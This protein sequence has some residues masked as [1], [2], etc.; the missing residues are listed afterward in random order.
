MK[1]R[2]EIIGI[3]HPEDTGLPL[4][5]Q[6]VGFTLIELL[7]VIGIIAIA[8]SLV[9][10]PAS[11][12]FTTASDAQA[13]QL[14]SAMLGAARGKAIENQSYALVHCQIGVDDSCWIAVMIHNQ[15]TDKFELAEG[16]LPQQVPGNIAFGE[17]SS[18]FVNG[19]NYISDAL[20]S[21]EELRDF[22][23]F[24]IVFAP[25]GALASSDYT[26]QIDTDTKIFGG[27]GATPEQQIWDIPAGLDINEPTVKVVTIFPYKTLVAVEN[28]ANWLEENG[29]FL[30]INPYTG[31]L[32]P[33]K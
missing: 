31:R 33:T 2:R 5:N 32:I 11:K 8:L 14:F 16:Y 23:T 25:S 27:N 4:F 22:T 10:P 19:G 9:L 15:D 30:C 29:Q 28:R 1:K 20:D 13:R 21:D 6:G 12:I 26:P 24:N 17:I 18:K 7:V 3:A